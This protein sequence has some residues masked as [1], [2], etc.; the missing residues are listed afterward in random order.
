MIEDV[1][2]VLRQRYNVEQLMDKSLSH[3]DRLEI[4]VKLETIAEIE[5]ILK[6]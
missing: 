2:D 1:L 5:A 6:G 4:I 3:D